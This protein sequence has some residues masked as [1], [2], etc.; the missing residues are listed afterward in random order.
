MR[1]WVDF[2]VFGVA[3]LDLDLFDFGVG[4]FGIGGVEIGRGIG[5]R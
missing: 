5:G 3:V 4:F 1:L 2:G